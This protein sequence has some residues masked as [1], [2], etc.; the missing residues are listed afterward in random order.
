MSRTGAADFRPACAEAATRACIC[1]VAWA[2]GIVTLPGLGLPI[3]EPAIKPGAGANRLRKMLLAAL[4]TVAQPPIGVDVLIEVPEGE[5]LAKQTLNARL[6]I[7]GRAIKHSGHDW[8]RLSLF[9]RQAWRAS[10]IQAVGD[11]VRPI[12][13]KKSGV[14]D[15][16]ALGTLCDENFSP[17]WPKVA[18]V[19]V[20]IFTGDGLKKPVCRAGVEE[21]GFC[22]DDWQ[23]WSK[24]AQGHFCNACRRLI[25]W[26]MD[27]LAENCDPRWALTQV[28]VE[29]IHHANTARHFMEILPGQSPGSRPFNA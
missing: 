24:T 15:R 3:G 22:G 23:N 4:A 29:E 17:N 25:R 12:R 10:V 26:T 1:R 19:E 28:V 2:V 7:I 21:R 27:F 18:F 14:S 5:A 6:G 8:Y 9:P 11:G 13:C 20:S 16:R